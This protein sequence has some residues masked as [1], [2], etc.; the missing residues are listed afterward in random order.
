MLRSATGRRL[1]LAG[2]YGGRTKVRRE[3][4]QPQ[5]VAGL[6]RAGQR[7]DQGVPLAVGGQHPGGQI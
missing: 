3:A 2:S 7:D 5:R 6:P 1:G 4:E